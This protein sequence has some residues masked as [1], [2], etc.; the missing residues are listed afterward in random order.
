MPLRLLVLLLVSLTAC[1][2]ARRGDDDDASNDDDSA[3][4][5]DDDSGGDDDDSVFT[6]PAGSYV[7]TVTGSIPWSPA[8]DSCVGPGT[9]VVDAG[10]LAS[11]TMRCTTDQAAASCGLEINELSVAT[12]EP[13]AVPLDCY[14]NIDAFLTVWYNPASG[15]VLEVHAVMEDSSAEVTVDLRATMFLEVDPE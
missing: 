9:F 10:G 13:V 2:P 4:S 1:G 5:D 7:G 12:A 8:S 3:I 6:P 14:P 11:G 15:S